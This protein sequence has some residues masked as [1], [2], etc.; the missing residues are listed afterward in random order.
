M[1][2]FVPFCLRP[3]VCY[4]RDSIN[5][6]REAWVFHKDWWYLSVPSIQDILN[7]FNPAQPMC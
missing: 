1:K 5:K 4:S 7:G 6:K 2:C 3:S